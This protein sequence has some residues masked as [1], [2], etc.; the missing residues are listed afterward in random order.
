M[1]NCRFCVQEINNFFTG[2]VIS[3]SV[4]AG[5]E[6]TSDEEEQ[7]PLEYSNGACQSC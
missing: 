4:M 2:T 1:E 7:A 3:E 6:D 5:L